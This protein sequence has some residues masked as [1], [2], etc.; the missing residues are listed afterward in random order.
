MPE[1][2]DPLKK[3]KGPV[4]LDEPRLLDYAVRML[5]VR[6]YSAGEM[7]T[8][9]RRKG[10]S[11]AAV[12]AVMN[13]LKE[14]GILNDQRFAEGYAAARAEGLGLGRQRV[15]RDLRA[16]QVSASVAEKAA[17]EAY[18]GKDEAAMARAF[19]ERKFRGKDLA[20]WLK[21]PKN[22]AAAFR[23][24]RYAGFSGSVSVRVLKSYSELAEELEDAG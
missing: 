17:E 9:L 10:E 4:K 2:R 5:A 11:A 22:L 3:R 14:Y 20:S 8:R 19:L 16:R 15:I 13:K 24:L 23:R 1:G 6:A 12:D 18:A 21:E 7:R